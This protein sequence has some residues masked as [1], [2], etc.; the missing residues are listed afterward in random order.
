MKNKYWLILTLFAI[1]A[2]SFSCKKGSGLNGEQNFNN[3]AS[4]A[5]GLNIGA[6]LLDSLN[7]DGIVPNLDEFL[8]GMKDGLTGANPR[9]DVTEA[10]DIIQTEYDAF[11]E[12][13][14]A[15]VMQAEIDFLAENAKKS[16][17]TITPSGLQYEVITE[18]NGRK[19]SAES[20]VKV[21]YE[22]RLT[23]GTLFDNS[24]EYQEPVE[25]ALF[26]VIPGWS[27]GLQLMGVGS[28][29]KFYI[30]SELGYGPNGMGPIPPYSALVFTV[31]LLD[32]VN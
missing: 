12:E 9:F 16:G 32:I 24:Y 6:G 1:M 28:K 27:E 29:Y 14:N 25:F 8:K 3:D 7:A 2:V 10:R 31:E 20:T 18:T 22:G 17:I 5:M 21:H 23:D 15:E 4:Y 30:P 26:Q 13:K 11:M 19:P